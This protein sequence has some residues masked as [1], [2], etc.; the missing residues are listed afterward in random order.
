MPGGI[1]FF[2]ALPHVLVGKTFRNQDPGDL[3][4]IRL[5]R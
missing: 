1:G 3:G 4:E 5:D 2:D